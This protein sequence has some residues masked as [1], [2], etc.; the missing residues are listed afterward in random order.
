[1]FAYEGAA[2]L[3]SIRLLGCELERTSEF[4][5]PDFNDDPE[6]PDK[7]ELDS[8]EVPAG[9][10]LLLWADDDP[11]LGPDHLRFSLDALG[12]AVGLYAPD[13]TAIDLLSFGLQASDVVLG[14]FPD[15]TGAWD[16]S[17]SATPGQPNGDAP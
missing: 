12:E 17:T 3:A 14:R 11:A 4:W 10:Q 5:K 15:G 16:L 1:M 8:L 9:G 7:H 2:K 13:G 6:E